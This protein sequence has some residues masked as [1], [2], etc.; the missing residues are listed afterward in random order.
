MQKID[1]IEGAERSDAPAAFDRAK[2]AAAGLDNVSLSNEIAARLSPIASLIKEGCGIAVIIDPDGNASITGLAIEPDDT[3]K[4]PDQS[5]LKACPECNVV[6]EIGRTCSGEVTWVACPVCD[7][8]ADD[9]ADWNAGRRN[10]QDN[11]QERNH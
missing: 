1:L 5:D 3:E 11:T 8:E 2:I 7:A 10:Y 9:I 4:E 6:P